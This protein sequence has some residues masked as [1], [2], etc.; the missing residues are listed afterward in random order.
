MFKQV[1]KDFLLMTRW[2]EKASSKKMEQQ[3]TR[4]M[5]KHKNVEKTRVCEKT[6]LQINGFLKRRSTSLCMA[7]PARN[8]FL[9]L[10]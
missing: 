7:L 6:A 3:E 4:Q 9:L 5:K 10:N 8:T 1:A 2:D